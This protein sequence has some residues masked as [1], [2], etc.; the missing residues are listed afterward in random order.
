MF[1][2]SRLSWRDSAFSPF[3]APGGG[4]SQSSTCA[5][6]PNLIF[7]MGSNIL[8]DRKI[9]EQALPFLLFNLI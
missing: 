5:L 4:I 6:N 9:N 3:R 7:E 1:C 8:N 2:L